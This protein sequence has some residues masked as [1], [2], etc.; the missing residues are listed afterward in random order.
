[1]NPLYHSG[2]SVLVTGVAT[3]VTDPQELA[4]MARL[5][6]QPWAPDGRG[7]YVRIHADHISGRRLRPERAT[8]ALRS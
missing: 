5:P 2:W 4:Q 3:L 8:A 1:V 7:N 6:L